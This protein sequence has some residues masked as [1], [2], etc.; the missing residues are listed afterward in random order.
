MSTEIKQTRN[1]IELLNALHV[2]REHESI[3]RQEHDTWT[4]TLLHFD[5]GSQNY[6]EL[7]EDNTV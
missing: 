4:V 2:A 6:K 1:Q 5:T 7:V 3:P